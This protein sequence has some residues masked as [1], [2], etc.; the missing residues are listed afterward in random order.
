[1]TQGGLDRCTQGSLEA[2]SGPP[3]GRAECQRAIGSF[4]GA[5]EPREIAADGA[6]AHLNEKVMFTGGLAHEV[7]IL[8]GAGRHFGS[9]PGAKTSITIMRPPQCGHGQR[10]TDGAPYADL[11]RGMPP[12][13]S[14]DRKELDT[15]RQWR[16]I[17]LSPD[18][19][20]F[21]S[22]SRLWLN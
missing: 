6:P 7:S 18:L 5:I 11:R 1:V 22:F 21:V 9:Q 19:A 20:F 8:L 3:G 12:L 10:S 14:P 13:R 4:I 2:C 17:K 15:V 16:S